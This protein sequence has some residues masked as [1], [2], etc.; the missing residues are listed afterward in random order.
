MTRRRWTYGEYDVMTGWD[1][2]L[3]YHFLTVYRQRLPDFDGEDDPDDEEEEDDIVYDNL[4]RPNPAMRI[5]E[6]LQKLED[7]GIP[8]PATLEHD[9]AMDALLDRGNVVQQYHLEA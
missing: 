5:D 6:I 3:Q 9:L 1:R 7:L 2:P 4:S 8:V